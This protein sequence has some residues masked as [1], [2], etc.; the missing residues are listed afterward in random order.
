MFYFFFVLLFCLFL[1][2]RYFRFFSV[3]FSLFLVFGFFLFVSFFY[4]FFFCFWLFISVQQSGIAVFGVTILRLV[5]PTG[6]EGTSNRSD[7][8]DAGR[9]TAA[10]TTWSPE[11]AVAE[12]D[13]LLS[14]FER[15]DLSTSPAG[16]GI[17]AEEVAKRVV[18]ELR[19]QE[20]ARRS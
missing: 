3:R 6:G 4:F 9:A 18:L 8:A 14:E 7:W 2:G 1:C 19:V 20:A 13:V 5:R 11:I 12:N 17:H 10:Q 16:A 15:K